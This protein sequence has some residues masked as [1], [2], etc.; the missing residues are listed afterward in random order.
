MAVGGGGRRKQRQ[1]GLRSI[2]EWLRPGVGAGGEPLA[3]A[4]VAE[5]ERVAAV[6]VPQGPVLTGSAT[7]EAGEC[8]GAVG[9]VGTGSSG[10][11]EAVGG[12][13]EGK[14]GTGAARGQGGDVRRAALAETNV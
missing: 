8:V 1:G 11:Q 12:C 9:S 4:R 6:G 7:R 13:P 2:L 10:L 14:E 3:A 5:G